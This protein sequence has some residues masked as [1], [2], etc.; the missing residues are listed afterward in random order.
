MILS[1]AL[2]CWLWLHRA[3]RPTRLPVHSAAAGPYNA[4]LPLAVFGVAGINATLSSISAIVSAVAYSTNKFPINVIRFLNFASLVTSAWMSVLAGAVFV[5][6]VVNSRVI[7]RKSGVL[8]SLVLTISSLMHVIWMILVISNAPSLPESVWIR[9]L[10][11]F[12]T[13]AWLPAAL[14]LVLLCPFTVARPPTSTSINAEDDP[15]KPLLLK[16][17]SKF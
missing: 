10:L 9:G 2:C 3:T 12:A 5:A 15:S 11:G 4:V 16:K 6:L 13:K 14:V 1:H 8:G 17:S 7:S